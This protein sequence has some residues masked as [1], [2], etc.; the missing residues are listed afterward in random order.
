MPLHVSK[1]SRGCWCA[2]SRFN[3][4]IF[5]NSWEKWSNKKYKLNKTCKQHTI[6]SQ[7]LTMNELAMP[8]FRPR[9]LK[10]SHATHEYYSTERNLKPVYFV[11]FYAKKHILKKVLRSGLNITFIWY[12][13]MVPCKVK[14]LPSNSVLG[15]KVPPNDPSTKTET[16][17]GFFSS[18]R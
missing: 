18:Y 12:T 9:P 14:L 2:L 15:T 17:S 7:M 3:Y 13:V 11:P 4:F 5:L 1:G 10:G 16:G 8:D 6:P